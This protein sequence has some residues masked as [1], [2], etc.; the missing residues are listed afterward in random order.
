MSTSIIGATAAELAS[1]LS[2]GEVS[3]VAVT[4]AHLDRIAAHEGKIQAFLHVDRDDALR[5]AEAVDA[6]RKAGQALGK[7]AG[8]PIAVKD[9]ACTVGQPTTCASRILQGFVPPYDAD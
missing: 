1:L 6:K 3:A 2:R 7:L 5:Q 4:S 8:L 9:V